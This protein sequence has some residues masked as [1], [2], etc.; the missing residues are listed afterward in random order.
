MWALG[1]GGE[2]QASPLTRTLGP[3]AECRGW[4]GAGILRRGRGFIDLYPEDCVVRPGSSGG[5]GG[6]VSVLTQRPEA[7]SPG[8]TASKVGP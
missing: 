7:G 4:G 8:R 3:K 5:T 1:G 2:A 6:N